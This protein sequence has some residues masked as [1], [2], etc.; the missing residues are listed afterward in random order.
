MLEILSEE[1]ELIKLKETLKAEGK[2]IFKVYYN[3]NGNIMKDNFN[4]A[5]YVRNIILREI[6]NA[7]IL[8]QQFEC[9]Q[10]QD[11]LRRQIT[12][13]AY[14]DTV[15]EHDLLKRLYFY[16][17]LEVP[18]TEEI[19]FEDHFRCNFSRAI[20]EKLFTCAICCDVKQVE[21][22]HNPVFQCCKTENSIDKQ[23]CYGCFSSMYNG[24]SII[25]PW[26][27]HEFKDKYALYEDDDDSDEELMELVPTHID[28]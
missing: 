28:E 1:K 16:A 12:L 26:C 27:K 17:N 5:S 14:H 21:F 4:K 10:L 13:Q 7:Y 18:D 19:S 3:V 24:N 8:V 15:K 11:N 22:F 23:V 6:D 25:C 2:F 9:F 20:H